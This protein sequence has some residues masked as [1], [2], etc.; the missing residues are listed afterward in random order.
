MCKTFPS[1]TNFNFVG[2]R[3][4]GDFL[5]ILK[6]Q[7]CWGP[8]ALGYTPLFRAVPF[9]SPIEKFHPPNSK[10]SEYSRQYETDF[11]SDSLVQLSYLCF[12]GGRSK[13]STK[14][15][16]VKY[17]LNSKDKNFILKCVSKYSDGRI[18]YTDWLDY[19]L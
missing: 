4:L 12:A 5:P 19:I 11:P 10:L 7:N 9:S 13:P 8:Y 1:F 14:L 17:S 18:L 6:D 16:E 3:A 2:L 15:K